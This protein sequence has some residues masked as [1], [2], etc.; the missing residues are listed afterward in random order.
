MGPVEDVTGAGK[1]LQ[2]MKKSTTKDFLP[3]HKAASEANRIH[4]LTDSRFVHYH[5]FPNLM[6]LRV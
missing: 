2:V 6:L 4:M 3:A 1:G 5:S